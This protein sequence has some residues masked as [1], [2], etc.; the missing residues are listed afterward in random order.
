MTGHLFY[1][2]K[3]KN[4]TFYKTLVIANLA[5]TILLVYLYNQYDFKTVIRDKA[6]ALQD[7]L[8]IDK[9]ERSSSFSDFSSFKGFLTNAL[10][11]V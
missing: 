1:I 10:A 11:V 8:G 6:H 7:Y 3:K 9:F 2:A 4:S 5:C